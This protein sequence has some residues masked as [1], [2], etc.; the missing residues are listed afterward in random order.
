MLGARSAPR[1]AVSA[2]D[3]IKALTTAAWRRA[4]IGIKRRDRQQAI[5]ILNRA[6]W[7]AERVLKRAANRDVRDR[8]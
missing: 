2:S 3:R 4:R 8:A 7:R 1:A 5:S 6:S